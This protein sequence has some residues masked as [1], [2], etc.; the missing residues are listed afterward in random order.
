MTW[1]I[2]FV[3]IV[4]HIYLHDFTFH[5]ALINLFNIMMSFEFIRRFYSGY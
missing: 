2:S 5:Y 1:Y 4:N 3:Y